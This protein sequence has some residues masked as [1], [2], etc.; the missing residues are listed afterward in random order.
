LHHHYELK[1]VPETKVVA[2]YMIITTIVCMA[3]LLMVNLNA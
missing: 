3:A 2:V 1:G